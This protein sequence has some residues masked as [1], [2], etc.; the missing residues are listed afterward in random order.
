MKKEVELK[1]IQFESLGSNDQDFLQKSLEA[2]RMSYSPYSE[3]RVGCAVEREDG[4]IVL[5]A[6]QENSSFPSGLCAERVAL[7]EC[8]KDLQNR[9]KRIA[10]CAQSTKYKVPTPLVPCA[11]CL[12]VIADIRNRQSEAIEI[13][14]WD[15]K[16]QVYIAKDVFEFLP[17]HFELEEQ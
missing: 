8:A 5:G 13:W 17:F 7:F 12:Q 15:T 1:P 4:S 11:G 9:V 2:T 3:F 14:M 6:N 16:D 10:V